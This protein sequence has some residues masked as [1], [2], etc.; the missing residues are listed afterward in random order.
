MLWVCCNYLLAEVDSCISVQHCLQCMLV[1]A[2]PAH[3]VA[4]IGK[5]AITPW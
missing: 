5:H 4:A 2:A 1:V 3:A